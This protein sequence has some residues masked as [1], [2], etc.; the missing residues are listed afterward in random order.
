[1]KLNK[2]EIIV[3][4]VVAASFIYFTKVL[5]FVTIPLS[6]ILWAMGG[7]EKSDKNYRRVGVPVVICGAIAIMQLN[8][9]PLASILPFHL[10]LRLGYGVPDG[11]DMGSDLGRWW[12]IKLGIPAPFRNITVAQMDKVDIFVRGTIALLM[13]ITMLPLAFINL[14]QYLLSAILLTIGMPLAVRVV[15]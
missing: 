12:A 13:A 2:E 8:V 6:A 11:T 14:P 15:K 4:A 10:A 7:A 5:S 3:G 9:L 1:M